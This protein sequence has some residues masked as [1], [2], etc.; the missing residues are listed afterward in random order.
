MAGRATP[1]IAGLTPSLG[2]GFPQGSM[3]RFLPDSLE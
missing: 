1:A 3:L 2:N